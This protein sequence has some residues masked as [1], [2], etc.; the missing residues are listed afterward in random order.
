MLYGHE[1]IFLI[2]FPVLCNANVRQLM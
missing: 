2:S 1:A